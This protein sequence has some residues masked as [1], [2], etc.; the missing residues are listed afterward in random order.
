[1]SERASHV[2]TF[3]RR[4]CLL[5]LAGLAVSALVPAKAAPSTLVTLDWSIAQTLLALGAPLAAM[6]ET[7]RYRHLVRVPVIPTSVLELGLRQEPNLEL[8][9]QLA[10]GQILI[11]S[12]QNA[13]RDRLQA[14]APV[15]AFSFVSAEGRPLQQ[16]AATTREIA[17]AVGLAGQAEACIERFEQ[18]LLHSRQALQGMTER[19]VYVIS[20]VDNRRAMVF[21][22]Q[23]LFQD[24]LDRLGLR[25]A[26]DG[27]TNAWGYATI[28][29]ERLAD[30]PQASLV[31]FNSAAGLQSSLPDNPIW[32]RLEFVRQR[33]LVKFPE[34]LFFGAL[35][36][37]D[38][39]ARLL[40]ERLPETLHA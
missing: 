25:N 30:T 38:E 28:G 40:A 22:R 16:A 18:R 1:M 27:A 32:N 36:A 34:V 23:S 29:L 19:P 17:L 31:Y 15:R 14:I 4:S 2:T 6:A 35:P 21:G 11:S 33:R 5:G 9:A 12:Y 3:G 20:L 39:F 8:L 10:P 26:W 37:A 24:V 7:E 13:L